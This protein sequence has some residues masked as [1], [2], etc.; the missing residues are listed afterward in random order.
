MKHGPLDW[1]GTDKHEQSDPFMT[2]NYM[3]LSYAWLGL[4]ISIG[5]K[6]LSSLIYLH[7]A[8]PPKGDRYPP[9][10]RRNEWHRR[11]EMSTLWLQSDLKFYLSK[12]EHL[13]YDQIKSE[14]K[15]CQN[16]K[17]H[18]QLQ[19]TLDLWVTYIA[20][21]FA[22]HERCLMKAC[23][24]SIFLA[25]SQSPQMY[26]ISG[27]QACKIIPIQLTSKDESKHFKAISWPGRE[28]VFVSVKW[29]ITRN[30]V[31]LHVILDGWLIYFTCVLNSH[32]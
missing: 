7:I 32:P 4:Y 6:A 17:F 31:I 23:L 15:S 8:Y 26:G 20:H 22:K 12:K 14:Q 18:P 9:A 27:I 30:L 19:L 25:C 5:K 11:P 10:R 24:L 2:Q 1:S 13:T 3:K 21:S 16:G 28:I 29:D